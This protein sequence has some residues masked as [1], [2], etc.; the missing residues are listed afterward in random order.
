M[1]V[2][3]CDHLLSG[4]EN[5]NIAI[6]LNEISKKSLQMHKNGIKAYHPL[7]LRVYVYNLKFHSINA[8]TSEMVVVKSRHSI[9]VKC[10]RYRDMGL[11]T[12]P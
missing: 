12:H 7:E 5:Q 11:W 4:S 1:E 10:S 2:A 3:K 6:H 8:L 9:S